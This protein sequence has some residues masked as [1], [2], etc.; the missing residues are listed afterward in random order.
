MKA[1]FAVIDIE[2]R[3]SFEKEYHLPYGYAASFVSFDMEEAIDYLEDNY[4][5]E[6]ITRAVEQIDEDGREVVY[7][8]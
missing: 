2:E 8:R 6:E 5:P 3:D 1:R 7:R 4:G